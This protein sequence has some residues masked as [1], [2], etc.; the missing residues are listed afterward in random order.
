MT[1]SVAHLPDKHHLL[2]LVPYFLAKTLSRLA[3]IEP[4]TIPFEI[5]ILLLF[6]KMKT[7]HTNRICKYIYEILFLC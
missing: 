2:L 1:L 5:A 4:K 3:L 7:P 6:K